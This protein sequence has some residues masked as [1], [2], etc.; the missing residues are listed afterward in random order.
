[1]LAARNQ[2]NL[3][4]S[5]QNGAALK[6]QQ[7]GQRTKYPNT[8]IKVP[9]KDENAAHAIG[10]AK[11]VLG[12]RSRGNE[13]AMTS[14]GQKG[15][16]KSNFVTPMPSRS[17]AVLGDKT[18]NAKAK[19]QQTVNGK[20][21]IREAEKSQT[22]APNTSKPKQKQPQAESLKLEVHADES[23]L[24]SEEEVE[25]CPPK[26]KDLPYESDVFPDGVLTFDALKPENRF[27]GFYDYYF[28]PVDEYGVPL[29]D[30]Q[31][32]ARNKKALE[33]GERQI[34]EDMENLEWC[35]DD[36]LELEDKSVKKAAVPAKGPTRIAAPKQSIPRKVPS[37]IKLR[38][39]AEALSMDDTTKSL[40][41]RVAKASP[42]SRLPKKR[43]SFATAVALRASRK[44]NAQPTAGPKRTPLEIKGIEANSRSTIGY[45]KG[46]ATASM[47]ARG[48]A[49]PQKAAPKNPPIPRPDSATSKKSENT[50]ANTITPARYAHRQAAAAQAEDQEWKARV[51][52][53]SIFNPNDG[54]DGDDDDDDDWE[55]LAGG[56]PPGMAGDEEGGEDDEEEFEL[57]LV[58]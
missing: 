38:N 19:G 48:T 30:R 32:E 16:D 24:L 39:A 56:L 55:F 3:V 37:T 29:A 6:Q 27:K 44:P 13:N 43:A 22:K 23:D 20:S 11:S 10:G 33:E 28:N 8:P 18:T 47:L 46:R 5:H 31:L 58:D 1:M 53:L 4:Y 12:A 7:Q 34:K 17:R 50:N 51:P 26:P 2:E 21:A 52:F 15:L 57:K 45:S 41:R 25:Y 54:D 49:K 36:E 40:Q 35:I 14:K 9:L 42:T